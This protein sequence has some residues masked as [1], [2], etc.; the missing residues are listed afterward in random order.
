MT[1]VQ[2][3]EVVHGAYQRSSGAIRGLGQRIE[4][5]LERRPGPGFAIFSAFYF[6]VV[7]IL[8]SMKLLWLDELI[9]LHI[10]NLGSVSAIWHAL[11]Q[12]VD[13][14]P[15]ITYILVH[16]SRSI[17][18]NH[19]FADRLPAAVGYWA[20]LLSLFL[21]LKNALPAV[22]ALAGSVLSTCMAAFNYSF[23]SRS[24]GIFYGLAMLGF[25][26]WSRAT[27]S[28]QSNA[29]RLAALAGMVL[30]LAA[31]IST[32]YFAVLALVP[33]ATGEAAR[34]LVAFRRNRAGGIALVAKRP[35]PRPSLRASLLHA[36][37]FRVWAGLA[38]SAAP[39]LIYRPLIAHSI[40]EFAPHAWNK[41]SLQQ[42]SDS[43]TEMLEETF[44]PILALFV[45]AI[46]V[47]LIARYVS[48][49]CG[50]CRA[51]LL[52]AWMDRATRR[53]L[54]DLPIPAHEA[55]AV[56]ALVAYPV[57]GYTMAS[58]HGGMLSP[59]FVIP[60][61]FGFAIAATLASFQLFGQVRAAGA[62]LLVLAL[63]WFVCRSSYVGYWYEEQKQCFYKVVDRL[64]RAEAYVPPDAPIAI[65]DP[66]MALTFMHYAPPSAAA[67]V[68]FPVDFP[69]I[70]YFRHDDSPDENL[71]AGRNLLYHL[72]I[73]PLAILQN[74]AGK[75]L[76]LAFDGNWM[77]SDLLYHRYPIQKLP[78]NTRARAIGGFTPLAHGAPAFFVAYGGDVPPA[79]YAF[80]T[81]QVP[82]R[83][84]DNLPQAENL[85]LMP[86]VL[87]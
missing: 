21:Y 83:P 64:P 13:P 77:L 45:F 25:F 52:P 29:I 39:L 3:T 56:L 42:L 26:C 18:G 55:V 27:D 49:C 71:W 6:A 20:G 85:P 17:F 50:S 22:W 47:H 19:E 82:F 51:R 53:P 43:Y 68:V 74:T 32:N 15:P 36:I 8:S 65:P 41:V 75:Y 84:A 78:I 59:R 58:I 73:V 76:V 2:A 54:R 79:D 33:I 10:A 31:G 30:A 60:V 40:A 35:Q 9:T 48:R 24:Y 86:G 44:Y 14:N 7:F 62:C 5:W 87:P 69:A 67:R 4:A 23:E 72:P 11:G 81:H 61:C 16:F 34:T 57:L 63:A 80:L 46:G 70:R 37:D 38:I 28:K 12:G 66:L 1:Y